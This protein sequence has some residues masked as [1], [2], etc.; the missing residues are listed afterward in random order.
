MSNKLLLLTYDNEQYLELLR[1]HDLPE[2]EI[3]DDT[4]EHIARTN[5]WLADPPLAAPIVGH[6][7]NL[8]WLQSTYAGVDK[9]LLASKRSDYQLTNIRDS[10]GPTM[11]EYVFSYLI[12]HYRNHNAYQQQQDQQTWQYLNDPKL[13]NKCILILGTGSIGQHLA[14]T[15]RL[16][17]MKTIGVSRLGE[18]KA[19][20]DECY[21]MSDLNNELPKADVVVSVL[22]KSPQTNDVF[23]QHRLNL[24]KKDVVFF[25]VGRG[26][27]VNLAALNT[28]L[29]ERPNMHAVLDVFKTEPL[30][31]TEDIWR[32]SN[33]VITPHVAAP[34]DI[35]QIVEVFAKNYHRWLKGADLLY[36]VDF[37]LGY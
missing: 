24:L 5:I 30:P 33:V 15:A 4:P 25:N 8:K 29:I 11:S 6:A 19:G 35:R 18:A 17:S 16:F 10:F 3:V 21:E 12:A 26:N 37:E 34:G 31:K 9:L 13:W 22:P 14:K 20:F 2:L 1:A 36:Q 28:L 27:A 23:D 32:R 7:K